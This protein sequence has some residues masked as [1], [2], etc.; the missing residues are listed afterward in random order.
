MSQ[1]DNSDRL[2]SMSQ[3]KADYHI[4]DDLYKEALSIGWP[5]WGGPERIAKGGLLIDRLRSY[6]GVPC[7]GKVLDV[8]CGEGNISRRLEA[9]GFEVSGVDISDT[10]IRWAKEKSSTITY[11]QADLSKPKSLPSHCYHVVVDSNCYHCILGEDRIEFL[12]NIHGAMKQGGIFFVSSLCSKSEETNIIKRNGL[13]YRYVSSESNLIHELSATGF[14]PLV[15]N[16]Y[17]GDVY[18]HITLHTRKVGGLE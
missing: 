3:S 13:P 5:G 1:K 18:D 9:L 15:V 8:G 10:A 7:R 11:F 12:R 17:E 16:R 14:I 2:I 4:H 6:P